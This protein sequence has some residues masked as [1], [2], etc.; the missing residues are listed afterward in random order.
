MHTCRV[1][2]MLI[3][4]MLY[5]SLLVTALVMAMSYAVQSHIQ[6]SSYYQKAALYAHMTVV[7]DRLADDLVTAPA[8]L[9]TWKLVA[10]TTHI[11]HNGV[12]DVG[13]QNTPEGIIRLQGRY[14]LAEKGWTTKNISFFHPALSYT[15]EPLRT[16]CTATSL[17]CVTISATQEQLMVTRSVAL[18]QGSML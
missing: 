7:L 5:S 16:A 14:T 4:L 11:W 18:H 6:T 9:H 17:L 12:Q 1:G 10:P 13:W 15:I 2:Y 8:S 3:E